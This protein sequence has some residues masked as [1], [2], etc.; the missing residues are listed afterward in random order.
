MKNILIVFSI[1]IGFNM[2]AQEDVKTLNNSISNLKLSYYFSSGVD[3][4]VFNDNYGLVNTPKTDIGVLIN[5]RVSLGVGLS[6]SF[7]NNMYE[8]SGIK[9]IETNLLNPSVFST[10]VLNPY[11]KVIF[12]VYGRLSY[13]EIYIEKDDFTIASGNFL[14]PSFGLITNINFAKTYT[15]AISTGYSY[16]KGLDFKNSIGDLKGM[17]F[18][19]S[20]IKILGKQ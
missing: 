10:L 14:N 18:G 1:F 8:V 16:T 2:S 5:D 15:V 7:F 9:R 6:T 3:L 4:S 12:E 13:N 11:K 20:F 19:F 17:K